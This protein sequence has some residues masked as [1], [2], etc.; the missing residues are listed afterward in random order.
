MG[1]G[2][3][4]TTTQTA[5]NQNVAYVPTGL[6]G[7]QDIYNRAAN[8]A[9]QAYQPYTGQL[10]QGLT[11]TQ[12]GAISNISNIASQPLTAGQI[13]QYM[14]PFQSNVIDATMANINETNNQ[15][16]AQTTGQLQGAAGGIGASRIALGQGELARQQA[17]ASNQTLA[18]LQQQNY[19]QA[20]GAAQ[21]Q[22]GFGLGA[23]QAQLGAGTL[24]QQTGQAGLTAQYQQYLQQLAFPY[25]Q[26]QFLAGIGIPALGAMGGQQYQ[27]GTANQVTT[28]PG[29][30]W[31]QVGA[32]LGSLGLGAYN[33]GIFG[34]GGGGG[35]ASDMSSPG[36][37]DTGSARG[38]R[39]G[40]FAD[41]GGADDSGQSF[42]PD[43][44]DKPPQSTDSVD[45]H[46]DPAL[47]PVLSDQGYVPTDT[48][49][50]QTPT[51]QIKPLAP[52][53]SPSQGGSGSA[54]SGTSG[55]NWGQLGSMAA[56]AAMMFMRDGGRT[57]RYDE[58]GAVGANTF[59]T[60]SALGSPLTRG[61]LPQGA[62]IGGQQVFYGQPLPNM[63]GPY[64]AVNPNSQGSGQNAGQSV[65][66]MAR[67]AYQ[68]EQ[69]GKA[70]AS[71]RSQSDSPSVSV[72]SKEYARGG[73][74]NGGDT[75]DDGQVMD[76]EAPVNQINDRWPD[77]DQ[78]YTPP[79]EDADRDAY[80]P[81]MDL[82]SQTP[83]NN[84]APKSVVDSLRSPFQDES[85]FN[86]RWPKWG[87]GADQGDDQYS[88]AARKMVLN[89][90]H[91]VTG[92]YGSSPSP[93]AANSAT[94]PLPS[95]VPSK[96][97]F[98]GSSPWPGDEVA[99]NGPPTDISGDRAPSPYQH[100]AP[101]GGGFDP[102]TASSRDIM[103]LQNY[104]DQVADRPTV[105]GLMH[106]PDFWMRAGLNILA[107]N[108]SHGGLSAIASG[109]AGT[110]G[111]Y[112]KWSKDDLTS[113]QKAMELAGKLKEHSDKY[114]KLT[115]AENA[116]INIDQERLAQGRYQAVNY[117]DENG[118][119]Q[120]GRF[121]TKTGQITD[122]DNNPVHP[123][124]VYGR[125]SKVGDAE[126]TPAQ[127]SMII[128]RYRQNHPASSAMTDDEVRT[129][130]LNE[131][132]AGRGTV[133]GTQGD[134]LPDPGPG[135]RHKGIYY[136]LQDGTVRPWQQD[137]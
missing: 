18:G 104:K 78:R 110:I 28:P 47:A 84:L 3:Q 56:T 132:H 129:N 118:H 119:L 21:Q 1:K 16:M 116:R 23:A 2:G 85:S 90:D 126:I 100:M 137:E 127:M 133:P 9:S 46:E 5:Q 41:G 94:M 17:L 54:S 27:T 113:K 95:Q 13:Q 134:P 109:A 82:P 63:L 62:Q 4:P 33:S 125:S 86:A 58:G 81:R 42:N 11:P 98:P 87:A 20:L 6:S 34:G 40:H 52:I 49:S 61:A 67:Q 73:Y 99:D 15:Q 25:Q 39:I 69:L 123:S 121:N 135:N 36:G 96:P 55:I 114:T 97:G 64:P 92:G 107:A 112:D 108:P 136:K 53:P 66:E 128:Q 14:N 48:K 115:A 80:A 44:T 105:K 124:R 88:D 122:N 131:I 22:Q 83:N 111:E 72:N 37:T 102:A 45:I 68:Q 75:D 8:V 71:M 57:P 76:L 70:L 51:S 79:F 93:W 65:Y 29:P 106:N 7:F 89:R 24:Q 101:S 30:S 26:A 32:G 120:V 130:A 50:I 19:A 103:N 31:L 59:P 43:S 35:S 117:A 74:A 38:G 12:T 10:V 60:P 91:P 77:N